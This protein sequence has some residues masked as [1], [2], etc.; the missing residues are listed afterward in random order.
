MAALPP[1]LRRTLGT[2]VPAP[3]AIDSRD[4][5]ARFGDVQAMTAATGRYLVPAISELPGLIG[6]YAG[7]SPGGSMVH[8]SVWDSEEHANQMARLK[9]MIVDARADAQKAGVSFTTP[10]VNYPVGWVV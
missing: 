10:I 9:E 2:V 5:R 4:I 6:Y 7:V 8:V 1:N 3:A